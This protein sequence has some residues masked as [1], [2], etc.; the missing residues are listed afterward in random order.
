MKEIPSSHEELVLKLD[1]MRPD[2]TFDRPL[3]QK[4]VTGVLQLAFERVRIAEE[5]TRAAIQESTDRLMLETQA[6]RDL[7]RSLTPPEGVK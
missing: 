7:V 5:Q 6:T 1:S 4:D 2:G 3:E